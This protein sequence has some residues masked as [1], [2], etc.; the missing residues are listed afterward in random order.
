MKVEVKGRIDDYAYDKRAPSNRSTFRYLARGNMGLQTP[1]QHELTE[2]PSKAK[3]VRE[4]AIPTVLHY[5]APDFPI[6][7]PL[8]HQFHTEGE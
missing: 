1:T 4:L 5:S 2:R 6:F 8:P 7:P 3:M